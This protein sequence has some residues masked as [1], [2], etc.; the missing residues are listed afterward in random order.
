MEKIKLRERLGFG[1]GVLGQNLVYGLLS[2]FI[3]VYYTDVALLPPAFISILFVGARV[4]DAVNDPMMGIVVDHTKTKWGKFRPYLLFLPVPIAI[5]TILVFSVPNASLNVKMIYAAVTY[6]L[7]G[8]L[9]TGADIPMW[10]LTSVIT[11]DSKQRTGIIS[12]ISFFSFIG[13]GGASLLVV[14]LLK[15]FGGESSAFAYQMVA[16]VFGVF[17]GVTMLGIFFSTKERVK[18]MKKERVT[19]NENLQTLYKNKPLLLIM[20]SLLISNIAATIMGAIMIYFAKYNLGDANYVTTITMAMAVPSILGTILTNVVAKRIGKKNTF[21][22]TSILRVVA[23]ISFFFIGYGSITLIYVMMG[24]NGFL[25]VFPTVILTDM[26][27]DTVD[28]SE[29]KLGVRSE[30]LA[31]SMRTFTTKLAGAISGG[32][33][34]IVLTIIAYIPNATEQPAS[35]LNGFF[36]IIT[37]YSAIIVAIG[38]IPIMFYGLTEDKMEEIKENLEKG[39]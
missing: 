4:W 25:S 10:S 6:V 23:L 22:I 36:S 31:F 7:W 2:S 9:F 21:L 28:Y 15:A 5:I 39:A 11:N 20:S 35:A 34:A 14:P 17:C 38:I 13:I 18:P 32:L 33:A 30:G 1:F 3:L 8:M 37:I 26:I 16:V 12:L 19:L 29:W 27:S 24:I